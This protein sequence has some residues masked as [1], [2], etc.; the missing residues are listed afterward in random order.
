[1][2]RAERLN[3]T[4][5]LMG[6]YGRVRSVVVKLCGEYGIGARQAYRLIRA[7]RRENAAL[8]HEEP[9]RVREDIIGRLEHLYEM[10]TTRTR[11]VVVTTTHG[12]GVSMQTIEY[13][14]D[15]DVRAAGAILRE[16][17]IWRN[18]R[19]GYV[20]PAEEQEGPKYID[21]PAEEV[22]AASERLRLVRGK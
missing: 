19:P 2:E 17:G 6:Q 10:A 12:K 21:V 20:V 13:V 8:A 11:A 14:P 7:V 9:E 1:M 5:E 18:A 3:R 22:Q 4:A 15:P 16:L